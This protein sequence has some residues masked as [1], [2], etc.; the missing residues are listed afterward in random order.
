MTFLSD[1]W[2]S[3]TKTQ[4]ENKNGR[5]KKYLKIINSF[6]CY[7][8]KRIYYSP[9]FIVQQH[10]STKQTYWD[11]VKVKSTSKGCIKYLNP[12]YINVCIAVVVFYITVK[13]NILLLYVYVLTYV[14]SILWLCNLTLIRRQMPLSSC[15][16][17][18]TKYKP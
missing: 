6:C 7:R 9:L 18:K 4:K 12:K 15:I 13:W 14:C 10:A 11:S 2:H 17:N 16:K 1:F 5:N 8:I 3:Q